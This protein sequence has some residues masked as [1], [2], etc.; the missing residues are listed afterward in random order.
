MVT[1][2]GPHCEDCMCA[3]A[4]VLEHAGD[5]VPLMYSPLYATPEVAQAV[6]RGDRTIVADAA[7]DMWALG[8][9]AFELLTHQPVFHPWST[10]RGTI[11][12]QLCGREALPW[13]DGAPE[14]ATKVKQLQVLKRAVL[15][16]LQRE[17][18]DRPAADQVLRHWRSLFEASTVTTTAS[19]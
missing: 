12:A 13:E 17:P 18:E 16:C 11:W 5:T 10:T 2:C 4:W 15:E 19:L 8:V 14:Q 6:E 1:F 3:Y 7:A 9:M